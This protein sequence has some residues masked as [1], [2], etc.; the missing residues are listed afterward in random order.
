MAKYGEKRHWPYA[1][2]AVVLLTVFLS[3]EKRSRLV[4]TPPPQFNTLDTA[5]PTDVEAEIAAGYWDCAR[6]VIQYKYHFGASLPV[7]PP[8]D[9]ALPQGGPSKLSAERKQRLRAKYWENLRKVW[10]LPDTWDHSYTL[11]F[12]WIERGLNRLKHGVR[13]P[14]IVALPA[15]RSVG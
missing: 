1:V 9:F 7:A 12:S 6:N 4:E 10:L 11:T 14:D 5:N 3:A 13:T 8:V 15:R 2:A